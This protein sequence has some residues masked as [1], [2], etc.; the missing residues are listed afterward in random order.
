MKTH[1]VLD[2][3]CVFYTYVC[4]PRCLMTISG[5]QHPRVV[6]LAAVWPTQLENME[7]AG[8]SPSIVLCPIVVLSVLFLGLRAKFGVTCTL[9]PSQHGENWASD[10]GLLTSSS[11]CCLS[12][13]H[14][15]IQTEI[16]VLVPGNLISGRDIWGWEDCY[17][18]M[19]V[20]RLRFSGICKVPSP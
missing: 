16:A 9:H 14:R 19:R 8:V 13:H 3:W 6:A 5:P 7:G 4:Q 10:A 18:D 2:S 15:V 1:T 12:L 17:R 20:S 11:V